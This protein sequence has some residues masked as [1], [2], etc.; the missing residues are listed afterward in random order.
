MRERVRRTL[1]ALFPPID[2]QRV[3]FRGGIFALLLAS[4]LVVVYPVSL[5][6]AGWVTVDS[7][8]GWLAMLGLVFGSLVGNS[9]V[10]GSRTPLVGAFM[11]MLAV[12]SLTA[13]ASGEA[14]FHAK[15]VVLAT[16]VNN[17]LTQVFAGEAGTDPT[18]FNLFLGATSWSVAYWGSYALARYRRAWDLILGAAFCV[19]VNVSLALK[20]LFF[21][22]V[23]FSILS[24][25]LLARLHVASLSERWERRR[26]VP[27]A[28]ME[29]RVLRGGLTWTLVLIM[30]ASF[31]PRVGAAETLGHAWTTFE[32]PWRSV[33][34]EWQRFFAGVYGPS[35]IQGVSFSDVIRLGLA[36]NLGERVVLYVTTP[37]AHFLRGTAY[38]FYTGVGWKSTDDRA[39]DKTDALNFTGRK[40]IEVTVETV[41][42]HGTLLFAPSEPVQ[43]NIPRTFVYGEDKS[44]SSQMRARDR[45]QAS[46]KYSVVAAVSVASK[47]DLRNAGAVPASIAERYLQVPSTVP[48]RVRE[49]ARRVTADKQNAY[50]K[51]EAIETSLR[52]NYRYSTVVKSPPSGRDPVDWFLFDL[53]EDFCEYFASSMVIMLRMQGIPARVVEGYTAGVYDQDTGKY[54]VSEKNAHAWVEV[55]FAG[56]GWIE[57]EPTPSESVFIRSEAGGD[58][59]TS[60]AGGS[61]NE[62]EDRADKER[63]GLGRGDDSDVPQAEFGE[64]PDVVSSARP[65]ELDYKPFAGASVIALLLA[66][67]A[68]LRFELR[69]RG[70]T[71]TEAAFGKTRLLAAY[72]G[73]RQRPHQ[74]VLEY[75]NSL[76]RALPRAREQ[77]A[78]IAH[79]RVIESYSPRRPSDAESEA[80]RLAWRAVAWELLRLMPRRIVRFVRTLLF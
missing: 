73:L 55:Y 47:E 56:F 27:G 67:A 18:P 76:G 42:P 63:A 35:R 25:L 38:D 3:G 54:V 57:F 2:R 4:A 30:L 37:E 53:R 58:D 72:A 20:P 78:T 11:G 29:W 14:P 43:A 28:D 70:L 21:D 39:T 68:W 60:G 50:D 1:R 8:F 44:F 12:I 46:G 16:N 80:A 51:A 5:D 49:L 59:L 79:A 22:L 19:V 52:T 62:K 32:A 33:E 15:I 17:W 26:L 41:T 13:V 48:A 74:T 65:T 75:A 6:Q 9:R 34:N 69:F 64:E 45:G 36:P 24:L 77:V 40:K 66:M 23:V 7:H 71:A 31:T 61:T 10:R